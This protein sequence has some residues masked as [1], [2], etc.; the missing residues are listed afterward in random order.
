MSA[1]T[2]EMLRQAIW[3][4]LEAADRAK[5]LV[6]LPPFGSVG[7]AGVWK[8]SKQHLALSGV[9]N[10]TKGWVYAWECCDRDQNPLEAGA[11]E[12]II[13]YVTFPWYNEFQKVVVHARSAA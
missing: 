2:L 4:S 12:P 9:E 5:A 13:P 11:P 6:W 3:D 1:R 10:N 8:R 7:M